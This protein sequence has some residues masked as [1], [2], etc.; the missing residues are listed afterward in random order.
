MEQQQIPHWTTVQRRKSDKCN[1]RGFQIGYKA[2]INYQEEKLDFF[3][4]LG[5]FLVK[6]DGDKVF[7]TLE[8]IKFHSKIESFST[9]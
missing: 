7:R 9:F 8:K 2:D 1:K 6:N 3:L 4:K 5:W